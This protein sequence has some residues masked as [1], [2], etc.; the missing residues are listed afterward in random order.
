MTIHYALCSLQLL[1][2]LGI[3]LEMLLVINTAQH[4]YGYQLLIAI[5]C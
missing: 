4:N 1:Q 3:T 2:K 5:D